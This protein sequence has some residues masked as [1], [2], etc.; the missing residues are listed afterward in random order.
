MKYI[1]SFLL[2]F[3]ASQSFA[4][5]DTVGTVGAFSTTYNSTQIS[6]TTPNAHINYVIVYIDG[7]DTSRQNV[8]D[9]GSPYPH[10]VTAPLTGLTP[11]TMYTYYI[12]ANCAGPD[13]AF[14]SNY[15]FTTTA[16]SCD[17][18]TNINVTV[19]NNSATIT[20][21]EA[22]YGDTYTI[23]YIRAGQVDTVTVSGGTADH[24]LSGLKN[25]TLY[26]YRIRTNCTT[27]SDTSSTGV[28]SFTTASSPNYTP[29]DNKGYQY[30]RTASDST[31]S[32]PTFNGTPTLR[33][34]KNDKAAIAYDSTNGKG[35]F[36]NPKTQAFEAIASATDSTAIVDNVAAM[37]AFSIAKKIIFNRDSARGGRFNLIYD[38]T[39]SDDNG[40]YFSATG[41]GSGYHWQR[42]NSQA[43][44]VNVKWFGAKGDGV[45]NDRIA[46]QAAI[47]YAWV[48]RK[49]ID[50]A[51]VAK[52]RLYG[53]LPKIDL[54]GAMYAIDSTV[55]IY[56]GLE[57]CNG[58][59]LALN[60][61]RYMLATP[62]R[63]NEV[64]GNYTY[65]QRN[66]RIHDIILDGANLA[67]NGLVYETASD[68]QLANI[69]AARFTKPSWTRGDIV[70]KDSSAKLSLYIK[71]NTN[72]GAY[73]N[74]CIMIWRPSESRYLKGVYQVG[75]VKSSDT[76]QV[77]SKMSEPLDSGD[78]VVSL[79]TGVFINSNQ[80]HIQNITVTNCGLGIMAGKNT[81]GALYDDNVFNRVHVQDNSVG[82]AFNSHER[83]RVYG[84]TAQHNNFYDIVTIDSRNINIYDWYSE[85]MATDSMCGNDNYCSGYFENNWG[86]V[87]MLIPYSPSVSG[88]FRVFNIDS[89]DMKIDY[90]GH[91]AN[92]RENPAHA[93]DKAIIK[94]IQ[95][96]NVT[97]SVTVNLQGPNTYAGTDS[98]IWAV[99]DTNYN[100]Y[101]HC[102]LNAENATLA[103]RLG[104][105]MT[106]EQLGYVDSSYLEWFDTSRFNPSFRIERGKISFG[107]GTTAWDGV[108]ERIDDN[109][110]G[111]SGKWAVG[112]QLQVNG[113]NG[114]VAKGTYLSGSADT[115]TG[116]AGSYMVYYPKK[117]SFFGGYYSDTTLFLDFNTGNRSFKWG[118]DVL[119]YGQNS[120]AFGD[121][122]SATGS[123]SFAINH[124]TEAVGIN[125]FAAG[126]YST[127]IGD[128]CV[129]MGSHVTANYTG[130]FIL[131]DNSSTTN[132]S[133]DRYNQFVSA[134]K[135]GY[136]WYTGDRVSLKYLAADSTAIY[137]STDSLFDLG[138]SDRRFKNLYLAGTAKIN[139]ISD[140]TKGTDSLLVESGGVVKKVSPSFA[141]MG[142]TINCQSSQIS[143]VN[144]A[145]SYVIG[146]T[147]ATRVSTFGSN[148]IY[149][150]VSGTITAAEVF[151]LNNGTLG[152]NENSSIYV[153]LN[154]TTDYAISSVL[155]NSSLTQHVNNSGLSI[156]VTAG[157]D[158]IEVK[159]V[160][161]TWSTNPTNVLI[162]VILFV[163]TAS[164]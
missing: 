154:N 92:Y 103:S 91:N 96:K 1:I 121:S 75:Y 29:M 122:T 111:V 133:T 48:F 94:M 148:K 81:S 98:L 21:D 16:P 23:F 77:Y 10:L 120:I 93:G 117:A 141:S 24:V 131:G 3:V 66:M 82:I 12:V 56:P 33:G 159:W 137:S 5:C 134:F 125:S 112:N 50:S 138:K 115:L 13:S 101:P 59:L 17:T 11:S 70:V 90:E 156:P 45:T 153:R 164:N 87:K 65:P 43:N 72:S 58:T 107:N 124:R 95:N 60:N 128:G 127:A 150:P 34:G 86:Y 140:G 53:N 157:T 149:F 104:T 61:M 26:Y 15:T 119:S 25:N 41:I 55:Q 106:Y 97:P 32:I 130:S 9:P 68:G 51:T 132:I 151:I 113:K 146:S 114:I 155:D 74:A 118:K 19:T 162:S 163:K 109:V 7:T 145:T 84:I 37:Q 147:G 79:G 142:Y 63:G 52:V 110:I 102:V 28:H 158:Y 89:R 4:Q 18:V 108:I 100:F 152:T 73:R 129:A 136:K 67:Y 47:E 22:A 44:G 14:T 126:G 71:V 78:I 31:A 8:N 54:G 76:L 62:Y 160:T 2:F 144:D 69:F 85:R 46:I 83:D 80:V 64:S 38:T 6:F 161:P 42:D 40:V 27:Y 36:F 123:S 143:T 99:I 39:I 105:R 57:F 30:K 49:K 116:P 139:T 88:F 135:A 20:A 35:Y